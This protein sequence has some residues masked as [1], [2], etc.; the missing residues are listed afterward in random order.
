MT[1]TL[2]TLFWESILNWILFQCD[3]IRCDFLVHLFTVC[4]RCFNSGFI[5]SFVS[6]WWWRCLTVFKCECW[7]VNLKT[8]QVAVMG[9]MM[10]LL[11]L[12]LTCFALCW[13][14]LNKLFLIY[15]YLVCCYCCRCCY[16]CLVVCIVTKWCLSLNINMIWIFVHPT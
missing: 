13:L 6:Q 2:I 11:L 9:W 14:F 12:L 15:F 5:A 10:L 8:A 4:N 7:G 16:C 1:I 3:V